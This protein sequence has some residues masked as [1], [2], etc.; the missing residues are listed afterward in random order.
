MAREIKISGGELNIRLHPHN[1]DT[2]GEFIQRLYAL[3]KAIRVRGERHAI[4]SLLDRSEADEGIY[5]GL[6]TTFVRIDTAEP[7]FD[8]GELKEA[9]DNKVSRVSI[10]E[11]L[12]PGAAF[13]NFIFNTRTHRLYF[14]TYSGG[15]TFSANLARTLFERLSEDL[16]ILNEFGEAKITIVQSRA[17]LGT[18]FNLPVIKRVTIVLQKPNA[19]IFDDDFDE[20]VEKYLEE[21][22]SKKLTLVLEAE[23]GKSIDPKPQL[24]RIGESALDHGSVKVD[25][26]DAQGATTRSTEDYPRQLHEKYDPDEESEAQAFRRMTGQ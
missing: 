9:A 24:R 5:A 4:I 1:N 17:G 21:L 26:R 19:D 16:N 3:R 18:V 14:Q 11:G 6:I 25:G 20:N 2:Y 7:W 13:F 23:A 10:P 15:K 12:H 22:N 8:V